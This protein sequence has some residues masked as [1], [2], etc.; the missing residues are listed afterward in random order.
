MPLRDW[1]LRIEDMLDAVDAIGGFVKDMS[2]ENFSQDRRTVD[3]VVRNLEVIGEAARFLPEP[4]RQQYPQVP[5]TNIIGM[6]S[7]LI[8]E[9]FGVDVDILWATVQ[10]D[11]PPLRAQLRSILDE[12]S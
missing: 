5:W 6:R 11:L 8:H 3:A 9:Y 4:V 7:V 1:S 12:S 10:N 2:F